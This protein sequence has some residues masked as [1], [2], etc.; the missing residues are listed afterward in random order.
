MIALNAN[1]DLFSWIGI[2]AETEIQKPH[3]RSSSALAHEE[4][5]QVAGGQLGVVPFIR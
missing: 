2:E 4:K 3:R 1:R 5:T